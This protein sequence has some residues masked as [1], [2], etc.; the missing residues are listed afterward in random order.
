MIG[1]II[2]RA[3]E[4]NLLF[5]KYNSETKELAMRWADYDYIAITYTNNVFPDSMKRLVL[6]SISETQLNRDQKAELIREELIFFRAYSMGTY[7]AYRSFRMPPGVSFVWTNSQLGSVNDVLTNYLRLPV[8]LGDQ[9]FPPEKKMEAYLT[10]ISGNRTVFSNFFSAV[11]FDQSSM[12]IT[13]YSKSIPEAGTRFVP[14]NFPAVS[15]KFAEYVG[16]PDFISQKKYTSFIRFQGD[17]IEEIQKKF[18]SVIVADGYYFIKCGDSQSVLP[19]VLRVYWDPNLNR[20]L[21]DDI[22]LWSKVMM[23]G[24]VWPVF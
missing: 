18:G 6:D 14:T 23:G 24:Y 20:W 22:P 21:P 2:Y 15:A 8:A 19:V 10:A 9:S 17:S 11:C 4:K 5:A 7:D 1:V 13:Q 3:V 16:M 12:V